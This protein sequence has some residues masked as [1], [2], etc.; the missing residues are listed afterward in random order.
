MHGCGVPSLRLGMLG[1][2]VTV[3]QSTHFRPVLALAASHPPVVA[4]PAVREMT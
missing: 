3:E 1:K 2:P 4:E